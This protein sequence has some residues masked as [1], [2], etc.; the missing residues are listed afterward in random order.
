MVSI[1][2][3]VQRQKGINEELGGPV[4]I[5]E[6][7]VPSI[8]R[9]GSRNGPSNIGVGCFQVL[10]A[11]HKPSAFNRRMKSHFIIIDIDVIICV[12]NPLAEC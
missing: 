5:F 10:G 11:N 9:L 12:P 1:V 3:P 8:N 4:R 6:T 2:E 7:L